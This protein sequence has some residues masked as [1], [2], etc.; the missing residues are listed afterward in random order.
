MTVES[1]ERG[2]AVSYMDYSLSFSYPRFV[3]LHKLL[4]YQLF[5]LQL[6]DLILA[7]PL[8]PLLL[9]QVD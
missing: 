7:L 6:L 3:S 5:D 1:D 2:R 8:F 9:L 4:Y